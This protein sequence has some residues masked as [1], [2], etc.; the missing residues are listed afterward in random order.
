MQISTRLLS[1]FNVRTRARRA[2]A[3]LVVAGLASGPL[4]S[5]C[6]KVQ[7]DNSSSYLI[8][9]ELNSISGSTGTLSA[10]LFSD[11]LTLGGVTNDGAKVKFELGMKNATLTPSSANF[12]TIN[13]YRVEFARSDGGT[14]V[15]APIE[16]S[17]TVTVSGGDS[18]GAFILVS[19]TM[20]E[21]SPLVQLGGTPTEIHTIATITFFGRDQAGR[22]VQATAQISV[23]FADWAD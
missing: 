17:F 7:D 16:G 22:D 10:V 1:F 13:R 12:I 6:A 2:G 23:H 3:L 9:A 8:I 21:N 14:G 15:P 19:S 4:V 18:Q 5:G 11:V 20:K